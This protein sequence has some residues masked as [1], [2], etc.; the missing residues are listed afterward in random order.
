[1]A[2][3]IPRCENGGG[4]KLAARV[5]KLTG[6]SM[7][8]QLVPEITMH[9]LSYLDYPSLCRLSMTNSLMRKVANDDNAWKALYRKDF[10]LEQDSLVPPDGWKAYYAATRAI[11]NI[12]DEFFRIWRERSLP[13]MAQLWLNSNY[14]KCFHANRESFSGYNAVMTSW[15][16]TFRRENVARYQ[17]IQEVR[18][19]IVSGMAWVTMKAYVEMNRSPDSVTNIYELHEGRWYIVHHHISPIMVV[20]LYGP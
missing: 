5:E 14:V 3:L 6:A 15:Q 8:E 19:R 13:A 2:K 20:G 10:S 17:E 9:A 1:M 4:E 18:A 12:N 7:M 11:V 16:M